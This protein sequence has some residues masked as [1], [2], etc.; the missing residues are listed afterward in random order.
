MSIPISG[1]SSELSSELLLGLGVP[2]LFRFARSLET[3]ADPGFRQYKV[4]S[5]GIGFDLFPQLID[6]HS[7]IFRFIAIVGTPNR[8]QQPA[9]SQRPAGIQHEVAQ[10][11][12]LFW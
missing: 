4:W 3:V 2:G 6:H 11:F 1:V 10:Q 9:M 12:E 7:Q 5:G 8:L